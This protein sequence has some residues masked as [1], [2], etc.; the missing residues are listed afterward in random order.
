MTVIAA[1][2][3][4]LPGFADPVMDAQRVFRAVLEATA[5]PGTIVD[6]PVAPPAPP[7]L[8]PATFAVALA[9][10]DFE[11]PLWLDQAAASDATQRTLRF[12]CGCPLVAETERAAFA[13]VAAPRTMPPLSAF[14]AGSDELPDRSTTLIIQVASLTGGEAFS[15]AGPGI[16]DSAQLAATGFPPDFGRWVRD[17]HDLFPRGVDLIFTCGALLAALP[18]STRLE[19]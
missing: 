6:C 15:L 11:T 19:G 3:G 17:N 7:P 10:L 14:H 2:D 16:R 12:H 9:L 13:I 4:L 18:R 1:T 5:R 8:D